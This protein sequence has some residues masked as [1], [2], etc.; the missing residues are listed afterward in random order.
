MSTTKN[1]PAETALEELV[2]F[3]LTSHERPQE[4][5]A[6]QAA[7][8]PYLNDIKFTC[9]AFA[10]ETSSTINNIVFTGSI[11]DIPGFTDYASAQLGIPCMVLIVPPLQKIQ[12]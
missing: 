2:R 11:L 6:I 3:G 10:T 12:R 9:E 1:I 8:K 7:L 4:K 5:D